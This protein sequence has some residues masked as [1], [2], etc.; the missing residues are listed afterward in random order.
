MKSRFYHL[1]LAT[2]AVFIWIWTWRYLATEWSENAQYQFGFAVPALA[3]YL[4]RR[5]WPSTLSGGTKS[6]FAFYLVA[7]PLLLLA[8][9]FRLS[10]PLWRLTGALWM[11]GAT[12]LTIGY[13]ARLGGWTLVRRMM[14]PLCFL[15]VALPWPMPLEN[16]VIQALTRI[17]AATTTTLMNVVG[18]AALQR[19]NTIQL[20]N[21]VVGIDT[22]CT[23]IESFQASL[24]VSLFLSGLMQLR[25]GAT[26]A[27]VIAGFLCSLV[28]NLCRVL[29]IA[30]SAYSLGHQNPAVH[31]GIGATATLLIF[32]MILLIAI[33]LRA[34]YTLHPSDLPQQQKLPQSESGFAWYRSTFLALAFFS[35]PWLANL[36]LGYHSQSTLPAQ[37]LWKIATDNLPAGWIAHSWDPASEQKRVLRFSAWT[38]CHV[39]TSDGLSVNVVHLFWGAD[40]SMPSTVFY[41]TPELCM[42]STGWQEIRDPEPLELAV[43]G[44]SVP[45]VSYLVGR[46]FDRLLALQYLRRGQNQEPFLPVSGH[47]RL[48]R[49]KDIWGNEREAV[50]EE[51]L[52]YMPD[53][54]SGASNVKFADEILLQMLRP[55][56]D[57]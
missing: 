45:F 24:M 17:V 25:W 5:N 23:G 27:L 40:H 41:H 57:G 50:S 44:R 12:V 53:R 32:T 54:G 1:L 22:A 13:F 56:T 47:T 51:I 8:E 49:L 29:V 36:S 3:F 2:P 18:I 48:D 42:P 9:L 34:K 33:G 10:D 52:I 35:I 7:W 20:A 11:A 39:I 46:D 30:W 6:W 19:G 15:W 14:F 16:Q 21:Q 4:A 43:D 31:D 38:G 55:A 28:V 37:P 26:L